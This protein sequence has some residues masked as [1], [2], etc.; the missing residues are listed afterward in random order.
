MKRFQALLLAALGGLIFVATLQASTQE[1]RPC[2]ATIVRVEGLASYSLGDNNW[3]PLVAGIYL[4]AG[5][6]IRTGEGG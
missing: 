5:S 3:R 2:Y 6:S 4:P 1:G